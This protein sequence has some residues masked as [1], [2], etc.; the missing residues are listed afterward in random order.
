MSLFNI[1]NVHAEFYGAEFIDNIYMSKYEYSTGTTYYQKA[2][3]MRNSYNE[4]VYCIDP[5]SLF[6]EGANYTRN[7]NINNMDP[8][9]I[10][11]IKKIAHFGYG[12]G[13][14]TD[15]VWYAAT[16]MLIWREAN[17][18][19]GRFYFTDT[20]NG[21]EI[22]ILENEM[23][24]IQKLVSYYNLNLFN[25]NVYEVLE[26]SSLG[27][28]T[29]EIINYYTTDS[30]NIK[31]RN[32]TVEV[33]RLKE[34]Y[35]EIK[36]ARHEN[37]NNRPGYMYSAPNCQS[38]LERGDLDDKEVILKIQVYKSKIT[39]TKLDKD[40]NTT[41]PQGEASLDGAVYGIYNKSNNKKVKELTIT[42]NQ[43]TLE[44]LSGGAY[45]IKE[46]TPGIGYELNEEQYDFILNTSN[47][48]VNI[49]LNNKVI[50]KKIIINKQYGEINNL[51]PESDI[52]FDIYNS[53]NEII[54]TIV[55][56]EEGKAEVI[57]PY[58]K[59]KIVQ[60]NTTPGYNKNN[61]IDINIEDKEEKTIELVDYK[62]EVPNTS[63]ESNIILLLINILL[64][65]L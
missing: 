46:I 50:E 61:P 28:Y 58:G 17:S 64:V 52:V 14:H 59:Y 63:S 9:T 5:F 4:P 53:N 21:N 32:N 27:I 24:E 15:P 37:I 25:D 23:N 39:V 49:D 2:K 51:S 1:K 10:D 48:I 47:Y 36:F 12:Y 22:T 65:I 35:H 44:G 29:G 40:T 13:N 62:I 20:L 31:I 45:Y 60:A 34:G 19:I 7:D 3:M 56:N 6:D 38:L 8:Y 42:N 30:E 41:S 57:L 18:N 11:K 33:W 43:A 16:Q 26:N 54:K 55:T